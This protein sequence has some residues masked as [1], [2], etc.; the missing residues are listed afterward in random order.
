MNCEDE[1]WN[2]CD[3]SGKDSKV[4]ASLWGLEPEDSRSWGK[5]HGVGKRMKKK[6]FL[7]VKMEKILL[8]NQMM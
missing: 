4:P 8:S 6:A 3:V 7:E 2:R 1:K 5:K